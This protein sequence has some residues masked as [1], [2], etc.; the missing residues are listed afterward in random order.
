MRPKARRIC[1]WFSG[2]TVAAGLVYGAFLGYLTSVQQILQALPQ[3]P[4]VESAVLHLEYDAV[5]AVGRHEV[6]IARFARREAHEDVLAL[7]EN[8]DDAVQS[9][10]VHLR[11]LGDVS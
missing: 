7:L 10:N 11:S 3:G 6:G 9:R 4:D 2:Y 1:P 5:V 8:L